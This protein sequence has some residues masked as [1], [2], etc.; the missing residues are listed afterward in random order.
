MPSYSKEISDYHLTQVREIMVRYPR[1]STRGL[2]ERL[3]VE[4]SI[5]I[6]RNYAV[7]LQRKIILERRN[8]HLNSPSL[9][10]RIAELQDST[11]I[12]KEML[13]IEA[14]NAKN[15]SERIRAL[16]VIQEVD[17]GLFEAEMDA[18]LF[19]R[20]I[21]LVKIDEPRISLRQIIEKLPSEARSTM[22]G[23][24]E[25]YLPA[26]QSERHLRSHEP[27]LEVNRKIA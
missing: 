19:E 8:R 20:K 2:V 17:L 16:K 7:K 6:H 10:E 4:F 13:W 26:I 22:I 24:L 27:N 21:G 18:G 25:Q 23:A 15:G 5:E 9:S 12:T 3:K 1:I 11:Q 14:K